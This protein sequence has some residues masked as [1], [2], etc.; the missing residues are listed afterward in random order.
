MAERPS[1]AYGMTSKARREGERVERD[2]IAEIHAQ[3]KREFQLRVLEGR[4]PFP[5][6]AVA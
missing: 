2:R 1:G 4:T 3:L 5:R 6:E